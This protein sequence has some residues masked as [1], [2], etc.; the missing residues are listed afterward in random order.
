MLNTSV[1]LEWFVVHA[2]S[3]AELST[4]VSSCEVLLYICEPLNISIIVLGPLA[5]LIDEGHD[6]QQH[7]R[8][9]SMTTLLR[10]LGNTR[11]H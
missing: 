4:L 11:P 9:K 3:A 2:N 1:R 7:H 8:V 5:T 10:I 6:Y